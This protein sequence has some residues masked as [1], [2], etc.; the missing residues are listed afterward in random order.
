V[1][2]RP[3]DLEI[4]VFRGSGP[5]GQHKNVTESAVRVTHLPTGI[6]VT[7]QETRSQ[8]RNKELALEELERRLIERM[9]PK[10]RRKPTRVT[11]TQKLKRLE[12]KRVHAQKKQLRKPPE[13]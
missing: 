12:G 8:H 2:L 9:R 3:E 7:C 4:D 13:P 1:E 6:T 11:K 10:K 5:G